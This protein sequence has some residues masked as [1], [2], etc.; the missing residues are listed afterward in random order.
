MNALL[1]ST[2]HQLWGELSFLQLGSRLAV[3]TNEA[4]HQDVFP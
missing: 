4:H 1:V 2:S 3:L